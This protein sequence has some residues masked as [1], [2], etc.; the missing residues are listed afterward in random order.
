MADSAA[1][2]LPDRAV[3]S[4][5]Y[6]IELQ[7]LTKFYPDRKDAEGNP[8]A[9][10]QGIDLR[11][12]AGQVFG[13]LGRNGAGK[14]TLIRMIA[15]LLEPTSGTIRV[16]GLDAGR[17][18]RRVRSLLGVALG[19]ERSVYWKLTARQNLEYFAALHGTSRRRARG[20]IGEVLEEMDLADRADDY[21]ER[22][23]TGMR[24]RLVIARAMLNRPGVLLLDEPASGLDPHAANNLHDH[25]R[26][27]REAGHTIL[28]TTHDM[29]EADLLSD[30]VGI[31]DKG[32]LVAT[33][34]P[35]ELKRAVGAARLLHLQFRDPGPDR[36]RL[37]VSE[38]EENATV[39]VNA[40][41]DGP[42]GDIVSLTLSSSHREDLGP[43]L[44]SVSARHGTTILRMENEL[45]TLRDA[46]LSLT[47]GVPDDEPATD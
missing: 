39:R 38:L 47:G 9:A 16:C 44:F 37:L 6:V 29:A 26:R 14:S 7:Q 5:E 25:I 10:V 23:S 46:F 45:V 33:G 11:V 8:L 41:P 17:H 18:R 20:R 28:V 24:Q 42:P 30:R 12:P 35:E 43:W 40:R 32:C 1:G 36:L 2:P 19:G 4:V 21:V 22:Y 27:L 34:T 3:R 15:T 13:L 31:I